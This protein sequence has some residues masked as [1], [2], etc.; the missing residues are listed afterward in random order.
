MEN[1]RVGTRRIEGTPVTRRR[2]RR[3]NMPAILEV[4][5][6][7]REI[8]AA[9]VTGM[10]LE[11]RGAGIRNRLSFKEG[12]CAAVV[13]IRRKAFESPPM[14]LAEVTRAVIL[15][16]RL[17]LPESMAVM[18]LEAGIRSLRESTVGGNTRR[19]EITGVLAADIQ[20]TRAIRAVVANIPRR[21]DRENTAVIR[22]AVMFRRLPQESTLVAA[23]RNPED[24]RDTTRDGGPPSRDISTCP[25]NIFK[26]GT[27]T[28]FKNI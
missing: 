3:E 21:A 12:M 8:T 19:R 1:I 10:R 11:I 14:I 27:R 18:T 13:G 20:R 4:I 25:M 15:Q 9:A 6:N 17:R 23:T 2:G 7:L 28:S 24:T 16:K 5:R 26:D 22:G